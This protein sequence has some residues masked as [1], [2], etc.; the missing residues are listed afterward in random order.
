MSNWEKARVFSCGHVMQMVPSLLNL[1]S[2]ACTDG[3]MGE[4]FFFG[5]RWMSSV[6]LSTRSC[7]QCWTELM[8]FW[9]TEFLVMRRV[10]VYSHL[11]I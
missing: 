2:T 8:C 7:V 6:H 3:D 1:Q 11:Y 5:P 4:A 10:F 9:G